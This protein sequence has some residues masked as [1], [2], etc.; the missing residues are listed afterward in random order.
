MICPKCNHEYTQ[1]DIGN[2]LLI[3]VTC[4]E[5]D[6]KFR[7]KMEAEAEQEKIRAENERILRWIKHSNIPPIYAA[8][9]SY[10][11]LNAV[12]AIEWDYKT[13]LL[14]IGGTGS[15]KTKRAC[16]LAMFGIW[17]YNKTARYTLH[18]G[19]VSRIKASWNSKYETEDSVIR[20]FVDTDILILDEVDKQEY[21]EYLFRVLDGRYTANKP[22]ILLS[23][24]TGE[25]VKRILGDALYS[26]LT[27]GQGLKAY[28]FGNK[29]FRG[30]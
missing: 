10:T 8:M 26:R 25:E 24:G 30:G 12:Q 2:G 17:K 9:R 16:W 3:P 21:T 27:K 20:D 23:N 19:L 4:P 13:P 28:N 1:R 7:A 5:C 14:F 6:R 22:T 15:G 18:S 11:P 29:D